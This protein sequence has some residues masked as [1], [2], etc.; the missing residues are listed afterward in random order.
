MPS[1]IDA[2]L[3]DEIRALIRSRKSLE[4]ASMLYPRPRRR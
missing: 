1:T 4:E 2:G 3:K